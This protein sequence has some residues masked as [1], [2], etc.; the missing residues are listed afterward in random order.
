MAVVTPGLLR[1][2][3]TLLLPLLVVVHGA[4]AERACAGSPEP[5]GIPLQ[6][7]LGEGPWQACRMR[8]EAVGAHWVLLVGERRIEF[9]HDG[10][11]TVT[12]QEQGQVRVV[13][14]RWLED[15]SLCWDGTC[16]RGE[17]PLD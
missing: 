4:V 16:A 13:T 15:H 17:I 6:C 14:S 12:M 2:L 1:P 11:G 9:R 8:V 10:S 5:A 7:R 3:W